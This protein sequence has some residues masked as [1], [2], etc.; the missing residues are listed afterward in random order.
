MRLAMV[1]SFGSLSLFNL[2]WQ[3]M[4]RF[5]TSIDDGW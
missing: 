4:E 1:N 2:L 5:T 3:N